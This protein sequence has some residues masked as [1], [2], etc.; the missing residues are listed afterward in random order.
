MDKHQLRREQIMSFGDSHSDLVSLQ[1]AGWGIAM[2]DASDEIKQAAR[3]VTESVGA[4][5]VALALSRLI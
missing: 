2:G 3:L 5:G 4:D 1:A